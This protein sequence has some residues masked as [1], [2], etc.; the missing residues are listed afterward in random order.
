MGSPVDAGSVMPRC[1][2]CNRYAASTSS[3]NDT[4]RRSISGSNTAVFF[5]PVS[6]SV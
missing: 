6:T 2:A 1:E 5:L 3:I 4:D